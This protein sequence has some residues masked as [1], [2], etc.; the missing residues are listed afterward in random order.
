MTL[1]PCI[2]C[3]E[4]AEAARC[5]EHQRAAVPAKSPRRLGYDA[6]WD[7]LSRRARKLQPFCLWCGTTEDLT[8]D[9]TPEAWRRK[10]A[11]LPIR[12]QDVRVLCRADNARAGS[13]RGPAPTWGEG[14]SPRLSGTHGKAQSQNEIDSQLGG[15][16]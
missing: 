12:L 5:P 15:E 8:T 4:P 9:H 1:R 7:R 2:D 16:Q 3:G 6:A 13:A 11:G 10:E 14:V